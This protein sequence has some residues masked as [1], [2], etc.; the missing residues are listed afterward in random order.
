MNKT[1]TLSLVAAGIAAASLA[2]ANQQPAQLPAQNPAKPIS[3]PN[4][5]SNPVVVELFTSQGCSS[6][7]PA[8]VLLEKLARN[9]GVVAIA[10][11]VTYWDRL[12]WRDTLAREQNTALQR[13]YAQKGLGGAGVYTPQIVVQGGDGAVGSSQ[14]EV[15]TLI[16]KASTRPGPRL[17]VSD[18]GITIAGG[19]GTG[20]VTLIAVKSSVNVSIGSG[21]NGGRQVRYTNVV[22]SERPLGQWNGGTQKFAIGPEQLKTP[23]AD[24]YAVIVQNGL[25]GPI[26][27]GGWL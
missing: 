26:L 20:T 1:I 18:G 16:A 27:T 21:E 5:A 14:G 7:P 17:T 3:G 8:D 15:R 22:K 13:A 25:A 6:C 4:G 2:L 12:G 10:R 23:G 19:R 9:P 24:R 11:P